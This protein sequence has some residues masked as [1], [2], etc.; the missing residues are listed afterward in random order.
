MGLLSKK[1]KKKKKL[2]WDWSREK[3]GDHKKMKEDK[4]A[5]GIGND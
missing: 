5:V 3:T 2:K 1:K 4:N